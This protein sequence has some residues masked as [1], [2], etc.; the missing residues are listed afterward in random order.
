MGTAGQGPE[1]KLAGKPRCSTLRYPNHEVAGHR[2][3]TTAVPLE[4]AAVENNM[5]L[6]NWPTNRLLSTAARLTENTETNQF[7]SLGITQAGLTALRVLSQRKTMSQYGLARKLRVSPDTLIKVLDRLER[8]DLITRDGSP[9]DPEGQHLRITVDG[10]ILLERADLLEEEQERTL[11]SDQQLRAELI[12]R[13]QALGIETAPQPAKPALKLV[14][15]LEDD[16]DSSHSSAA[17]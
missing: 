15:K 14:P 5:D 11:G 3:G 4:E 10:R 8:S 7:R 2:F 6:A 13:I 16:D 9:H 12:A 1:R 17:G